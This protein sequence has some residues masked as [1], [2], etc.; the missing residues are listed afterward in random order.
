MGSISENINFDTNY[1]YRLKLKTTVYSIIAGFYR[2]RNDFFYSN[3]L[4]LYN[5]IRN[6]IEIITAYKNLLLLHK[7][8]KNLTSNQLKSAKALRNFL[9]NFL[10]L[11]LF[12]EFKII[13]DNFRE[14]FQLLVDETKDFNTDDNE[15]CVYCSEILL[16]ENNNTCEQNHPIDRCF[17]SQLQIPLFNTITCCECE[18][19]C[20]N[21]DDI[22]DVFYD[23]NR[24]NLFCIF[25]DVQLKCE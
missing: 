21:Y 3:Y 5:S 8:H 23:S 9:I 16:N 18:R 17:I 10:E 12:D 1:I 24:N 13:Q 19:V 15:F 11:K 4:K 14:K 6:L 7:K 20:V 22:L 25:C 2:K